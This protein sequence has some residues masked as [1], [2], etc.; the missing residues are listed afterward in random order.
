MITI[1][2]NFD[3]DLLCCCPDQCPRGNCDGYIVN[4]QVYKF[5]CFL[6]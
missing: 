1:N 4:G 3:P 5:V 2:R 6:F